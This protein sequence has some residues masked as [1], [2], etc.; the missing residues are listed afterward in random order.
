[1]STQTPKTLSLLAEFHHSGD[2]ESAWRL[3]TA[4]P[5]RI[6]DYSYYRDLAVTAA[7]GLFDTLFFA[8]FHSFSPRFKRSVPWGFEPTSLLSA[9]AQAVP[10]IGIIAT[11]STVYSDPHTLARTFA[12]LWE[13]TKGR[14]GW[15]IVTAGSE[16]AAASYGLD[17]NPEHADRYRAAHAFVEQVLADW[18]A[19]PWG[20]GISRANR[21]VTVQAGSS[22][23]GR[24]FAGRFAELV[25]TAAP[26]VEA[27]QAF[28]RDVQSRAVKYGRSPDS[29]NVAPG[30][31]VVVGSTEEEARRKRD[32]LDAFVTPETLRSMLTMWGLDHV[33]LDDTVGDLA[34]TTRNQAIKSRIPVLQRIVDQAPGP[35]TFRELVRSLAGSRGHVNKTGTPEQVVDVMEEWYRRGAC[36]AFVIKF[37]HNPGGVRDFVDGVVPELQRRGLYRTEYGQDL[38]L[39]QRIGI[40]RPDVLGTPTEAATA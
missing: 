27:G 36:D 7:E 30:F 32:E 33:D 10:E 39:H 13:Q 20:F 12:T 16:A 5:E 37:S 8:D 14:V 11:A 3:P 2:H 6:S 31:L 4:E 22:D 28:R 35:I 23:D 29:V 25:F 24:E 19:D 21:P 34:R 15:N 9:I 26:D 38:T 40:T 1:M 18:E 17:Q